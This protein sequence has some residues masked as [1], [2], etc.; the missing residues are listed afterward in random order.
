MI[1]LT[2]LFYNSYIVEWCHWQ[3]LDSAKI[4]EIIFQCLENEG[5]KALNLL[6]LLFSETFISKCISFGISLFLICA[7]T[8]AILHFIVRELRLDRHFNFLRFSNHWYYYLRGEF[9]AFK[10]FSIKHKKVD[11]VVVDVLVDNSTEQPILYTGILKQYVID[12]NR[13]L[14]SI[15]LSDVIVRGTEKKIPTHCFIIPYSKVIN[16]NLRIV[17]TKGSK[18]WVFDQLKRLAPLLTLTGLLLPFFTFSEYFSKTFTLIILSKILISFILAI[19][20][21]NIL[22][23]FDSSKTSKKRGETFW[24]IILFVSNMLLIY[25]ASYLVYSLF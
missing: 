21:V 5:Y 18:T 9:L 7:L 25:G 17:Y 22:G 16:L 14:D 15:H 24:G 23:L 6:D 20:P 1:F 10:E 13:Q 12:A 4:K 2:A 8:G 3:K 11:I 19:L